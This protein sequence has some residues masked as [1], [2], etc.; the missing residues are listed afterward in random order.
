MKIKKF[1]KIIA[2]IMT[3]ITV[4]SLMSMTASAVPQGAGIYVITANSLNV[5]NGPGGPVTGNTVLNG[6]YYN[7]SAV[8]GVWG[9]LNNSGFWISLEYAGRVRN[10][11]HYTTWSLRSPNNGSVNLRN[12]AGTGFDILGTISNG[13][14][15]YVDVTYSVTLGSHLWAPAYVPSLN[16]YGYVAFC[17]F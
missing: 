3:W 14:T 2:L 7:I 9:E 16:K 12:G 6:S 5:R 8:N 13:S 1:T 4:V 17:C 10:T 11:N 15:V